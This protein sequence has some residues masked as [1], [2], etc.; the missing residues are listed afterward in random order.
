[1]QIDL[2]HSIADGYKHSPDL[3]LTWITTLGERHIRSGRHAEAAQCF[4]HAAA[5]VAEYLY[6][7]GEEEGRP[8]GAA[9]FEDI[10][11]NVLEESAVLKDRGRADEEVFPL[12]VRDVLSQL[13][14]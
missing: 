13:D 2:H 8:L 7:L 6:E 3:R 11:A 12:A 9:A 5:L 10:S 14:D 1:M 4:L